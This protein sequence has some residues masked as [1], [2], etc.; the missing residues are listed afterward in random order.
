MIYLTHKYVIEP[1]FHSKDIQKEHHNHSMNG[2]YSKPIKKVWSKMTIC[3]QR[4][5]IKNTTKEHNHGQHGKGNESKRFGRI[6]KAIS[7]V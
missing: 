5:R 2:E 3:I 1:K 4:K 6:I 7:S